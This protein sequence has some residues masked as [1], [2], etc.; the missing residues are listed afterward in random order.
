MFCGMC[1]IQNSEGVKKFG[2]ATKHGLYFLV[3]M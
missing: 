3:D 1:G 2:V